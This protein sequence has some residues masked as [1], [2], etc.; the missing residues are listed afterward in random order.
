MLT[1]Y[2]SDK[3]FNKTNKNNGN[4]VTFA[5]Q[6]NKSQKYDDSW[7]KDAEF[8]NCGKKGHIKPNCPELKDAK[9]SSHNNVGS[10]NKKE[11][12]SEKTDAMT[13][14]TISICTTSGKVATNSRSGKK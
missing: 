14:T 8:N 12:R 4:G 3:K 6:G 5:Q 9:G 7:H 2:K 13:S 11:T 10:D 1:N